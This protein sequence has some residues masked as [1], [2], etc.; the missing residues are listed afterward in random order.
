MKNELKERLL[1]K[2]FV[3]SYVINIKAAKSYMS[4]VG[5][6]VVK[7]NGEALIQYSPNIVIYIHAQIPVL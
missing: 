5:Y 4:A 3:G 7:L 2:S 6:S 1:Y